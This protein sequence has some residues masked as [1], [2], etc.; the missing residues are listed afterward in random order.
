MSGTIN[1]RQAENQGSQMPTGAAAG[2]T[3]TQSG[4]GQTTSGMTAGSQI[5]QI[6]VKQTDSK[7]LAGSYAGTD[8]RVSGDTAKPSVDAIANANPI[9]NRF[10]VVR[11]QTAADKTNIGG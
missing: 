4:V 7:N 2:A 10:N 9:A 3:R 5:P 11:T 6:V 8:T 1:E